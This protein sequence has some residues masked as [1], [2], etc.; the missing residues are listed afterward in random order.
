MAAKITK[1]KILVESISSNLEKIRK[2]VTDLAIKAG[3]D[4]D[5]VE[6]I[7][8]AVDECTSNVVRHAYQGENAFSFEILVEYD[9]KKFMVTV[10]DTGKGF[11][12]NSIDKPDL[13]EYLAK[14]K[15]GGLGI[16][17]MNKL[18]DQVE[19]SINPGVNNKVKMTKFIK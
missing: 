3:F 11:D 14:F 12:P 16:H 5:S 10:T 2:F 13:K 8:L 18:M 7:E 9:D 6:N 15:V 19:Y 1:E 4:Q 17:L